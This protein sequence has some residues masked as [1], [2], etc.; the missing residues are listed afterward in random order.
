[1]NAS[2]I[3]SIQALPT[4]YSREKSVAALRYL[5]ARE[6]ILLLDDCLSSVDTY[7]EEEIL[8]GLRTVMKQRTSIIV[9]HRLSTVRNA[10]RIF[11]LEHGR[12]V[13]EGHHDELFERGGVYRRLYD[14][15]FHST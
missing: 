2:K 14:M 12:V 9:A 10:D 7:T 8:R 3:S 6:R 11:V 13:E 4:L 1:M 5:W 15:Q